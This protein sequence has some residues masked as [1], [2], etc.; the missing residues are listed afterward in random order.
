MPLNNFVVVG[1]YRVHR[2]LPLF[3]AGGAFIALAALAVGGA[4]F[5][6]PDDQRRRSMPVAGVL[7]AVLLVLLPWF[8]DWMP[9]KGRGLLRLTRSVSVATTEADGF[10]VV[11]RDLEGWPEG[12]T[13]GVWMY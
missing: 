7:I 8:D 10:V 12:T 11:P 1:F 6:M 3:G 4:L 2:V 9:V 13:V 5:A